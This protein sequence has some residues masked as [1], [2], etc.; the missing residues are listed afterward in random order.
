MKD[1]DAIIAVMYHSVCFEPGERPDWKQEEEIFRPG[2]SEPIKL[3]RR[4]AALRLVQY[5]RDEAHRF[6]QHYHH[7]LRRK[8][9]TDE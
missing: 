2:E 7:M 6:A 4:S 5:V 8:R 3:S 9:L 1:I